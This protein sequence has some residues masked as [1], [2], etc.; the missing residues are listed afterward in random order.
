MASNC[1]CSWKY[2][3]AHSE[4]RDAEKMLALAHLFSGDSSIMS[5]IDVT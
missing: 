5:P 2:D 4:Q 3:K 1:S